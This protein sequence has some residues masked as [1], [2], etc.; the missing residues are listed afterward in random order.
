[1]AF[2][3]ACDETVSSGVPSGRD[4]AAR[5]GAA[6]TLRKCLAT[7]AVKPK[8]ELIRFVL[9]PE[10]RVVPD[11]AARLPGRGLWVTASREALQTAAGKNLFARAAKTSA[12]ADPS[13]PEQVERLLARRCLELLGLARGAGLVV[14]GQ[15]QVEEAL[16][17]GALAFV[18][19]AADAGRDVLKKMGR[20]TLVHSALTRDRLGEAL[21]REH[22][23]TLGL[24]PHILTEKLRTELARWQG[25][26][27]APDSSPDTVGNSGIS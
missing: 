13:L 10:N 4:A 12:H 15:P 5:A 20:A 24:R 2:T 19:V 3:T 18:L 22:L 8:A 17:A 16:K 9:D 6:A 7:G 26:R 1:M 11:L 21:G 27:A 23:V 14:T 25:V